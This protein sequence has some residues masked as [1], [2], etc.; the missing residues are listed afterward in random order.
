MGWFG[1]PIFPHGGGRPPQL[2]HGGWF[3]HPLGQTRAGH[4]PPD[5]RNPNRPAPNRLDLGGFCASFRGFELKIKKPGRVGSGLGF[6]KKIY[7]G[8]RPAPNLPT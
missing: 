7:A 6:K 1:H 5:P 2:S 8:T 4:N 3:G